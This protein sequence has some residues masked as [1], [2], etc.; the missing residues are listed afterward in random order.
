MQTKITIMSAENNQKTDTSSSKNGNTTY[1]FEKGTTSFSQEGHDDLLHFKK[2]LNIRGAE[3]NQ[4]LETFGQVN[5]RNIH[6]YEHKIKAEKKK[7]QRFAYFTVAIVVIIPIFI[8]IYTNYSKKLFDTDLDDLNAT[9]AVLSA[10]LTSLLGVHQLL[11]NWTE[12][13]RF[14]SNYFAAKIAL[15]DILFEL[16]EKYKSY[17]NS[18]L[19]ESQLEGLRTDLSAAIKTSR[20]IVNEETQKFMELSSTPVV[21][22]KQVFESSSELANSLIGS[23]SSKRYTKRVTELEDKENERKVKVKTAKSSLEQK[24][25]ALKAAYRNLVSLEKRTQ[26]IDDKMDALEDIG[27][28]NLNEDDLD[29][30]EKLKVKFD[31]LDDERDAILDSIETL[32]LEVDRL[33]IALNEYQ[34]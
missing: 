31:A 17:N 15:M 21:N 25:I 16:E 8:F 18:T 27:I 29:K 11:S 24:T 32:Q 5:I 23:F 26:Q 34:K 7:V 22:L 9:G 13:K 1:N 3:L 28:D 20:H 30:Y 6:F 4:L 33:E 19:T 2:K 14:R 12:K 10:L